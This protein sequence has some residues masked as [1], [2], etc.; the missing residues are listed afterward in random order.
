M[1]CQAIF[2]RLPNLDPLPAGGSLKQATRSNCTSLPRKKDGATRQ[3]TFA[4]AFSNAL[5]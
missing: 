2:T 4:P 5:P 1:R 3:V